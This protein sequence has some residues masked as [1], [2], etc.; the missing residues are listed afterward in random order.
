MAVRE[1]VK[2]P[3]PVLRKRS[4]EIVSVSSEEKALLADMLE[5]MYLNQGI[6]L[7]A[8]QIGILKRMIVVDIGSGPIKIINPV[9]TKRSGREV[10][11]EGCLSVPNVMID[12]KRAEKISY[13]GLDL[14]GKP[15]K[16]EA[17]GLLAR[18]LQ[19]EIDHLD[20]K[21]IIDYANFIKKI[22]LKK[23]C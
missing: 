5:T 18:A 4:K 12:I 13:E 22:L 14:D 3:A 19:H 1:I 7:A 17:D 16:G 8:P 9:I 23:R 15:M 10:S 11:Q 6:G 20:G 2:F 21:I